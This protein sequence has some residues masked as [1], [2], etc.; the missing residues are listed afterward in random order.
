MDDPEENPSGEAT[1]INTE[2]GTT[3]PMETTINLTPC[4]YEGKGGK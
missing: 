3:H 4:Q 2:I 1:K